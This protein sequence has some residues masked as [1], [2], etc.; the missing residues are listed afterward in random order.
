MPYT[1][2]IFLQ[3]LSV[4]TLYFFEINSC[5][6]TIFF[7]KKFSQTKILKTKIKKINDKNTNI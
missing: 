5:Y 2:M 3:N 7:Y 6:S 1:Q 4:E